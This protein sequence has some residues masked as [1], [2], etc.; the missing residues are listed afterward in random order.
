MSQRSSQ[1]PY[2]PAKRYRRTPASVSAKKA[3]VASK[4]TIR[5]ALLGLSE[6]KKF[7]G[8]GLPVGNTSNTLYGLNP[9]F[10]MASGSGENQRIGDSIYIEKIEFVLT[11]RAN[12]NLDAQLQYAVHLLEWSGEKKDGT[13]S[14]GGF[15]SGVV[16]DY[17]L[18]L[19][20]GLLSNPIID[21]S[22]FKV[23]NRV[24]GVVANPG[25]ITGSCID[26][27]HVTFPI[28]K[29]F[30]FQGT[31]GT[32]AGYSKN[33]NIYITLA[34]DSSAGGTNVVFNGDAGYCVYYKDM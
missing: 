4:A 11:L 28:N 23:K 34:V 29:K 14:I 5:K 19:G 21:D 15:Q 32:Q 20:T 30:Q 26:H 6:T 25:S 17:R 13:V 9:L 18:G 8:A 27:V 24:Q 22:V 1:G 12:A 10:W 31:T 7:Y 16:P 2:P 3:P 33:N